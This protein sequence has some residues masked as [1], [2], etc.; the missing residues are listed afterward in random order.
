MLGMIVGIDGVK[1]GVGIQNG[2]VRWICSMGMVEKGP[3][4]RIR[5][6]EDF[7]TESVWKTNTRVLSFVQLHFYSSQN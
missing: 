1:I 4:L 2:N 7:K 3:Q 6:L 5:M